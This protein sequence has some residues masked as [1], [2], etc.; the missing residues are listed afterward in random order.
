[1]LR[2]RKHPPPYQTAAC[3]A[4]PPAALL[5][6]I[7]QLNDGAY[8]EQ[9]ETLETLWRAEPDDVRYMYQGILLVGVGLYHLRRGNR[10]GAAIKLAAAIECLRWF[11]PRC[12][13]VDIVDLMAQTTDVLDALRHATLGPGDEFSVVVH[14]GIL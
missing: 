3:G 5:R 14:R 8:F 7:E 12:Q 1:M 6:A 11:T 2:I 13:T 4:P 10:S 9:H